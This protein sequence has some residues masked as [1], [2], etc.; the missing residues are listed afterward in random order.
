MAEKESMKRKFQRWLK[1]FQI[2]KHPF[3]LVF[4]VIMWIYVLSLIIPTLW[5]L[6]TTFK[7]PLDFEL[8]PF[9][10]PKRWM[11][12]NYANVFSKM[13]IAKTDSTYG[14][15]KVYV[16]E[17]MFNGLAY[18][19]CNVLAGLFMQMLVAYGVSKYQS[20]VGSFLQAFA[21]VTMI[22]PLVGSTSATLVWYKR[23][24]IYNNF[25]G[26]IVAHAGW[27]GSTFLLFCGVFKGIST[28]Y[29]DAALVDGAG[30]FRVFVTIMIPMVKT[31]FIALFILGFIGSWNDYMTPLM[32]LPSM[33]TI[34]Y[35]LFNFR[36][37]TDSLVSQ[38]PMQM[39]GCVIVMVPI[40]ILFV[41]F[42]NKIMGNLA[43]GGLKG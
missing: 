21:I 35:G 13:Y 27:G 22:L 6:I 20:K 17:L 26:I 37:S 10:S 23:L 43:I 16:P 2:L 1:N 34:A 11:F 31:S 19:I 18:S 33:P 12:E 38:I 40:I 32:F 8:N 24:N 29:R 36:N 39:T 30:H 5:L 9:G 15:I 4:Y 3:A 25:L 14:M 42:R 7:S 28:D 41:C